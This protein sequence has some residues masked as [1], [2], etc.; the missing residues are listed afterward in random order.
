MLTH[1]AGDEWH[2]RVV[3]DILDGRFRAAEVELVSALSASADGGARNA[4]MR[5]LGGG[6]GRAARG[7]H[8][9]DGLGR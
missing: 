4:T 9:P 2:A 7:S 5:G 6:V 3:Y 1:K 8:A